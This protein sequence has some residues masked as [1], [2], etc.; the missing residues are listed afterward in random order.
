MLWCAASGCHRR[1][2]DKVD[3]NGAS[4]NPESLFVAAGGSLSVVAAA[5][6]VLLSIKV[7]FSCEDFTENSFAYLIN[8]PPH[9]HS[10]Q[11][12]VGQCIVKLAI[13]ADFTH[14]E[15]VIGG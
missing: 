7:L 1:S 4:P 8:R 9:E 3:L 2:N 10:W 14:F 11:V 15:G 12:P 5:V 6:A 13:F